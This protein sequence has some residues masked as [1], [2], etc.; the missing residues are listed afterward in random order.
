MPNQNLLPSGVLTASVMT[1]PRRAARAEGLR[2]EIGLE[3]AWAAVDPRPEGPSSALRATRVAFGQAAREEG[4]HHL[5]LQDDAILSP[6]FV[7]AVRDAVRAFPEAALS[8]FVEWGSRTAYLARW[9]AFT[10]ADAV[11]VIN[12]YMPILATVLPR[13]VAVELARFLER[14][15]RQ[16]EPGD[17]EVLRFL[18]GAGV[19]TLAMVPNV[20]DHDDL[21]SIVGNSDHGPRRAVCTAA[22]PRYGG[23]VLQAPRYLPFLRWNLGS[24]VVIDLDRDVPEAHRST[25]RVLTEWGATEHDMG[26]AFADSGLAPLLGA[27]RETAFEAWLTAAGVGAV[28]ER[29]W[30]GTVTTLRGRRDEPLVRG[31]LESFVPGMLRTVADPARMATCSEDLALAALSAMEYGATHLTTPDTGE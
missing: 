24:S 4:G 20:V 3:Q 29:Y 9:A 18:R 2:S 13:E 8:F 19:P 6:G 12:P 15:G 1:H 31:A 22:R 14:E 16:D 27:G 26:E 10:G 25:R 21:P 30:P 7:D 5:V 23:S 11:P 17:R 28:Q